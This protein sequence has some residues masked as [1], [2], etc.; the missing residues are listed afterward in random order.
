MLVNLTG[1]AVKFT[2]EGGR[3][4]LPVSTRESGHV[5]LS[6]QDTGIG[7]ASDDISAIFERLSSADGS[8]TRK[9]QGTGLGLAISKKM[10]EL[11]GGTLSV[12]SEV[13]V[14]ST[15]TIELPNQPA[16]A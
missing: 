1:N 12:S 11:H 4:T 6:V 3:V 15:F 5:H 10:V 7:I 8:H 9:H 13:G 14:G 16:Q 2:E